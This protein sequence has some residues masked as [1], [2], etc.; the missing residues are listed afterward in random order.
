MTQ[1][2]FTTTISIQ[3]SRQ[4]NKLPNINAINDRGWSLFMCRNSENVKKMCYI[5]RMKKK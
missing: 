1:T 5:S 2:Y 4:K 3:K